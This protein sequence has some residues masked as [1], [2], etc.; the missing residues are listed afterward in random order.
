MGLDKKEIKQIEKSKRIISMCLKEIEEYEIEI[1]SEDDEK[2]IDKL[3]KKIESNKGVISLRGKLIGDLGVGL[4]SYTL[5]LNERQK[6]ILA[7]VFPYG[8]NTESIESQRK[9]NEIIEGYKRRINKLKKLRL[10]YPTYDPELP[11]KEKLKNKIYNYE[12]EIGFRLRVG[13]LSEQGT[14]DPEW[15]YKEHFETSTEFTQEEREILEHCA[16][17]G[18]EYDAYFDERYGFIAEIGENLCNKGEAIKEWGNI[19]QAKIWTRNQVN[20]TMPGVLKLLYPDRIYNAEELEYESRQLF[21]RMIQFIAD[22][23]A[24]NKCIELRNKILNEEAEEI[25]EMRVSAARIDA[26]AKGIFVKAATGYISKKAEIIASEAEDRLIYERLSEN[27][28]DEKAMF[29]ILY[30]T[31]EQVMEGLDLI[32]KYS[33]DELGIS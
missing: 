21:K 6:D 9:R 14:Y 3:K 15:N 30:T 10:E 4:E 16:Q 28:G 1:E 17:I 22:K 24:L 25:R 13:S 7:Q 20:D 33:P 2:K 11:V 27:I 5:E 18:M 26:N 29:V 23:E 12:K 8:F 32:A 31:S 19:T